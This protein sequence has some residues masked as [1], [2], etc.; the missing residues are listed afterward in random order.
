MKKRI[1]ESLEGI[2]KRTQKSPEIGIILGTGLE[3]IAEG[4]ENPYIIPYSDIPHFPQP[5]VHLGRLILGRIEGKD[6]IVMQGRIHYYEGYSLKEVTY[7]VMVL[8]LLGV[9][10][11]II[12]NASG[13]LSKRF[14]PSD[15]M[16]ITDHINFMGE[17]PLRGEND[18]E[19]GP[20]FPDM[21]NCYDKELIQIVQRVA[22]DKGITLHQGIYVGV[23]GPSLETAAEYRHFGRMGADAIGMSTVPEV[24]VARYRGMRVLALSVITNVADPDNL[25]PTTQQDVIE[26]AK[27]ASKRLSTLIKGVIARIDE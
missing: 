14:K 9:R 10:V 11:L 6:V 1:L 5:T 16:V 4:I 25:K 21:S 19:L 2:R 17:N 23:M 24:I 12:S 26:T 3:D 8:S 15:I 27:R 7:P 13:G 22:E 20:R 18:P